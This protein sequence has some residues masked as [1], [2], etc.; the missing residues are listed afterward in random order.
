MKR[1]LIATQNEGKMDEFNAAFKPLGY[2]CISLNDVDFK[3]EI[4]EDGLTFFDNAY[5]KAKFI[6]DKYDL[7]TL[8][9]DSGL[10]VD[11]L[12]NELGVKSKRFSKEATHEANNLLLLDKMKNQTDRTAYFI[13]QLV[14]YY[15]GGKF[16]TYQG[17]V[18]GEI[19]DD[20]RGNFG[21]GY[22]PLFIVDGIYKRMA[23]L[24]KEEKNKVSHRGNA[25]K[26]LIE[27]I[28]N[29]VIVI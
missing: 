18:Y 16:Y 22:D 11:A 9:D 23:N 1:I 27:D 7:V 12:P 28:K 29:E 20:L 5:I 17:R 13:S 26:K 4:I 24:T 3:G 25:L 2:R 15:P 21:F 10:I 8:A 19:A 14:L 6:A